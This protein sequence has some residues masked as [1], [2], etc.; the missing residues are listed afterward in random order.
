MRP[1]T[2]IS[3]AMLALYEHRQRDELGFREDVIAKLKTLRSN[4]I[5]VSG[6]KLRPG[7]EGEYSDEVSDFIGR[8]AIAGYVV[9]ESPIKLTPSGVRLI[10]QHLNE[11]L[12]DS[13]VVRAAA[14]LAVPLDVI[15]QDTDAATEATSAT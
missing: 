9:Q 5:A 15:R 12:D 7:I 4:Q 2:A 14:V 13:E 6:I 1:E 10:K 11:N 3:L 8:L